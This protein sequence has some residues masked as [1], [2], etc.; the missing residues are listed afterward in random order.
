MH[1]RILDASFNKIGEVQSASYRGA[2]LNNA[3]HAIT[4]DGIVAKA[5][6]Q[7]GRARS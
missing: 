1:A 6:R 4:L 3:P 5:N 2:K 7:E